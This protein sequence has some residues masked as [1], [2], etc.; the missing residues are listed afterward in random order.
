MINK[1]LKT[2]GASIALKFGSLFAFA[3]LLWSGFSATSTNSDFLL[4]LRNTNLGNLVIW[5]L[6][7][8]LIIISAIFFGRLWCMV[9]PMELVTTL[10]AKIGLKRKP[11][12]FLKSGWAITIFY[13]LVLIIG[14]QA[15]AI[16]RNPT[17]M[18][19]YMLTI[20]ITSII[21]GIIYE[22]NSF[23][24][25]VC[26]I[27]LLLGLYSKLALFGLR[28]KSTTS[29]ASCK[30]KSC[31]DKRYTYNLNSKSCGIGLYPAKIDSSSNCIL[32]GG[33]VR[34]CGKYQEKSILKE[35][36]NP[37]Y[38]RVPAATELF[39]GKGGTWAEAAFLVVLSGFVISEIWTEWGTSKAIL[40]SISAFFIEIFG[41]ANG[42][43]NKIIHGIVIFILLPILIWTLP[44]LFSKVA[45]STLK[46]KEYLIYYSFSFIPIIASAHFTK[47]I[48]KF[49]SRLG[50]YKYLVSDINGMETAQEILNNNIII[51]KLP[52]EVNTIVT[53]AAITAI[54]IG[55]WLSFKVIGRLNRD[56]FRE[57]AN[58]FLFSIP[59]IYGAI[60]L[61]MIILWRV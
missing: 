56:R 27:G 5:S 4:Q 21:I 23:C 45:G 3:F 8:P 2:N 33:C 12:R 26:P 20:A 22:K 28:V 55:I 46:L 41:F 13:I 30:D 17:Y 36:P 14:I 10:F 19:I 47:A 11:S 16:H 48:L 7:W 52:A 6:W 44:Y 31:I 25:Y 58:L 60:F 29:C 24:R 42:Q 53:I 9:C 61:V 32:C 54:L 15:F 51:T 35:R 1:I 40:N 50:Y 18:A 59:I 57:K 49:T 34:S 43:L 38:K 37:K 39:S